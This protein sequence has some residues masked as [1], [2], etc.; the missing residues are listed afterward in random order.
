MEIKV[1]EQALFINNKQQWV[2]GEFVASVE[3]SFVYRIDDDIHISK[4]CK[5]IGVK[6]KKIKFHI[7]YYADKTM[8]YSKGKDIFADSMA[9]ALIIFNEEMPNVEPIYI[10]KSNF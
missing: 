9:S 4:E 5:V 10:I 7:S 8:I 2:Q 1:G 3:D 6:S